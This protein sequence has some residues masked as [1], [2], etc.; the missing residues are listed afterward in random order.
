MS[1]HGKIAEWIH[2]AVSQQPTPT[3][4][5]L[6]IIARQQLETNDHLARLE[7][8]ANTRRP[9]PTIYEHKG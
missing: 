8:L 7:R 6:A 5:L 1:D 9:E 2:D 3:V 4:Q